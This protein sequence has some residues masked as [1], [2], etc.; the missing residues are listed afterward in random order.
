MRIFFLHI[1]KKSD[2]CSCQHL[3]PPELEESYVI[4]LQNFPPQTPKKSP[5]SDSHKTPFVIG[6][7]PNEKFYL[8]LNGNGLCMVSLPEKSVV[9]FDVT[10]EV[11]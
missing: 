3:I 9:I 7:L 1:L 10:T 11:N 6:R 4:A 8:Q 2:C 5:F